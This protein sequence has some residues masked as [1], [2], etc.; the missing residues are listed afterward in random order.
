VS[1][2]KPDRWLLCGAIGRPSVRFR[3]EGESE[4]E[5]KD[6]GED[7]DDNGSREENEGEVVHADGNVNDVIRRMASHPRPR[8]LVFL[9]Q[10]IYT[11]HFTQCF[12]NALPNATEN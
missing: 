5:C 1:E 8:E 3:H 7:E 10:L 6:E 11:Q 12:P 4:D 2:V 9:A